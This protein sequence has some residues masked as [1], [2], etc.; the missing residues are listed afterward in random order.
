MKTKIQSLVHSNIFDYFITSII[1]INALL[2]GVE[3]SFSNKI[4]S[5]IQL[6]C[7][8]IFIIEIFL[9]WIGKNSLSEYLKNG[10]NW[11]DIIIVL[12]SLIP[13]SI[14]TDANAIS[15]LRILRV[16]RIFRIFKAIPSMGL[17]A[18]VLIGSIKSLFQATFFLIIFMYIYAI[19]GV[20]LFKGETF[21]INQGK[22]IIDPYGSIGEAFF[23]L[24]RITT[25][26]DWTDLRYNLL[27]DNENNLIVNIY[28][29]SWMVLSAFLLLNIIVG[30]IVNNYEKESNKISN[31]ET[32]DKIEILLNKIHSIEEKLTKTDK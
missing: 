18:R 23:S 6:C 31:K 10:W 17:M 28:H 12:I 4:I 20:I 32:E 15:A 14:F 3:I 7:L 26:E 25:G 29:V 5:N 16:F 11:Y 24:F 1:F 2:I 27:K 30:A 9:R 21:V 13:E 19:I 8:I 22:E